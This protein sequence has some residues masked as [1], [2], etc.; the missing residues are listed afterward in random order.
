VSR[1]ETSNAVTLLVG[2]LRSALAYRKL[3]GASVSQLLSAALAMRQ[4]ER[5]TRAQTLMAANAPI[6]IR[7]AM[8]E[9]H[10]AEGVLPSGQVAGLIDDLPRCA[11]LVAR[12]VA[13]AEARLAALAP[14]A[15]RVPSSVRE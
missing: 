2:A 9:G 4:G 5:L 10:P 12:I 14:G 3:S 11:D 15:A 13:D 1:L 7:K 8:V 6:L